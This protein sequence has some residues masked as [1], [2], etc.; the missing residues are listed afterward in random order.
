MHFGSGPMDAEPEDD[1]LD[2]CEDPFLLQDHLVELGEC[3]KFSK[4][5]F[6]IV[7]SGNSETFQ[8]YSFHPSTS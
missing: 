4:S 8:E 5:V 6:F 3:H 1:S 7:R 2:E